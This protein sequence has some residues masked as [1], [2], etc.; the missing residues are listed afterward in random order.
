MGGAARNGWQGCLGQALDTSSAWA[1]LAWL[2]GVVLV[3]GLALVLAGYLRRRSAARHGRRPPP[4]SLEQ[5][6][7]LRERGE[8]SEE[9]YRSLRQRI[10][11][12]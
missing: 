6:R 3:C 10:L 1:G 8:L 11:D 9:E 5:L 2:G 12:G 4:F 7:H